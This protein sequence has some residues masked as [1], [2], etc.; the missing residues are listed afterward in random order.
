MNKALIRKQET[1]EEDIDELFRTFKESEAAVPKDAGD[2]GE[3]LC[4]KKIVSH[5]QRLF[6]TQFL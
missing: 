1:E 6:L 4:I 5:S 2:A 3:C